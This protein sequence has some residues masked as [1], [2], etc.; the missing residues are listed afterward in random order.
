MEASAHVG[1]PTFAFGCTDV[2]TRRHDGRTSNVET[3]SAAGSVVPT[4][5]LDLVSA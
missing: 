4:W 5:A 3:V 2:S 1:V